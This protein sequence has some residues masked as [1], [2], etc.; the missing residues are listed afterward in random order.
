MHQREREGVCRKG[1]DATKAEPNR[2]RNGDEQPGT[3]K[4]R[5]LPGDR[6]VGVFKMFNCGSEPIM[7]V[8]RP[9]NRRRDLGGWW[10]EA[11]AGLQMG[12]WTG[13]A[14]EVWWVWWT[15]GRK[16]KITDK[17]EKVVPGC[18]CVAPWARE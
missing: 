6:G 5:R 14:M 16:K 4:E 15:R 2:D 1:I 3:A 11:S 9:A 7:P 18:E 12:S 17:G 8:P 13:G 10:G